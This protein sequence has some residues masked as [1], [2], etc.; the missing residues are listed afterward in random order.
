MNVL[1]PLHLCRNTFKINTLLKN[2][3]VTSTQNLSTIKLSAVQH[4]R[5]L[6]RSRHYTEFQKP[7]ACL[8]SNKNFLCTKAEKKFE[9]D[10]NSTPISSSSLLLNL[11][12]DI[13]PYARLMRIDRPIGKL[14]FVL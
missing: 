3:L 10:E 9:N 8:S 4:S 1:R 5:L 2:V 12:K 14:A 11:K 6:C 13:T 7:I